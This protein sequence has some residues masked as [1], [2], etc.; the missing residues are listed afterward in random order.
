MRI[1]HNRAKCLLCGDVVESVTVHDFR[2][3]SCEAM[4]VDG[5]RSYIRR[6]GDLNMVESMDEYYEDDSDNT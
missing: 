5:G 3:C 1:K 4:F 6:G 2:S